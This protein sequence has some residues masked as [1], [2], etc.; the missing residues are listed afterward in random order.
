MLSTVHHH[1]LMLRISKIP[2]RE[3]NVADDPGLRGGRPSGR[4]E[5]IR[6]RGLEEH[7]A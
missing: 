6:R 7:D 2:A 5:K 3:E 1:L 4:G